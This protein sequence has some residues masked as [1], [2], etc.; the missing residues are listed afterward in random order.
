MLIRGLSAV[1]ILGALGSALGVGS[2][3]LS[4]SCLS[5]GSAGDILGSGRSISVLAGSGIRL[6]SL[7]FAWD[8]KKNSVGLVVMSDHFDAT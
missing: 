7:S 4:G 2:G 8:Q 5:L 3:R 1:F 6:S